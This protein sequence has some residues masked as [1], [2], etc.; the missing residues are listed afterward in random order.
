[1]KSHTCS[2]TSHN[3]T[4]FH[5]LSSYLIYSITV[6]RNKNYIGSRVIG[7]CGYGLTVIVSGI[8]SVFSGV[9]Y[10]SALLASSVVPQPVKEC[11]KWLDSSTFSLISSV[12]DFILNPVA[13]TLLADESQARQAITIQ[14][15]FSS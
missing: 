3:P 11:K 14:N 8:E 9:V 12:F 15:L 4:Q 10:G 7:Q 6:E 13:K 2:A 1:M 5:S